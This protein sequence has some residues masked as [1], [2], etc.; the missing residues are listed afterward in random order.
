M[1]ILFT[2]ASSFTG[3]WFSSA[4]A[5]QG[6]Q[7]T[8]PFFQ[9]AEAYTGLRKERI[10]FLLKQRN[11]TPF[12]AAPFGSDSFLQLIEQQG[13][14]DLIC[15]HASDVTNYKSPA[16][17]P[18]QAL[19]RNTHRLTEVLHLLKRQGCSR[20]LWTGSVFEP[21]EGTGSDDLRAVSPYGLS[22][23]LT[24]EYLLYYVQQAGF[25]L[26]KFVIANPFGPYEE[27]RFTYYLMKSWLS[28]QTPVV[29]SPDYRRDNI[30][31]SLMAQVYADFA[32]S[33]PASKGYT[34]INPSFYTETQ[35]EF[36][37]RFAR[38]M[39]KRLPCSCPYELKPQV[40][41]PEPRDRVNIDLINASKYLWSE[42][43][44]WDE[45]AHYYQERMP[46]CALQ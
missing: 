15:H 40:D 45:L 19:E 17:N 11:I 24:S 33:L 31:V 20:F 14:W 36:T 32:V 39:E 5:G 1:K 13:P 7:V 3:M 43:Q 6:H 35:G 28:G 10:D 16:F 41:F 18:T 2:G 8:T 42:S 38:E 22:K 27:E 44:A 25:H 46:L 34:K 4:L 12:W 29:G 30:P 21:S 9:Q 23:G 37:R 26:G